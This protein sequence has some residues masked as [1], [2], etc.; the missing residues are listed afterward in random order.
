[1]YEYYRTTFC[2]NS[3]FTVRSSRRS[4]LLGFAAVDRVP[5]FSFCTPFLPRLRSSRSLRYEIRL[6]GNFLHRFFLFVST[7]ETWVSTVNVSSSSSLF[8][9]ALAKRD[10]CSNTNS[11]CYWTNEEYYNT[12]T[13]CL[14]NRTTV[15][16]SPH[17]FRT[18][19]AKSVTY[20]R[21]EMKPNHTVQTTTRA[22]LFIHTVL[23]TTHS[24]KL[25]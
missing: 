11:C 12:H 10:V 23:F 7:E 1:M 6:C 4:V 24:N 13:Q 25:Q 8:F 15:V 5:V 20:V 17:S 9:S 16:S 22:V 3:L 21:R 19:V 2:T 14:K 18:R